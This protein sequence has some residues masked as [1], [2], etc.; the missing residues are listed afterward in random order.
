MTKN[1]MDQRYAKLAQ[2][3]TTYSV[4]IKKGKH[5]WIRC[6]GLTSLQLGKE[7]YK[8]ALKIGAHPYL[9]IHDDSLGSFY[10]SNAQ[11][12]QL[13]YPALIEEH[14]AN[15]ADYTI[16]LI[17][18]ENSR[19]LAN[20]ESSK[21]LLK[22]KTSKKVREIIMKKP[23][24]LTVIPTHGLA[25]DAMMSTDA[26]EDFYFNA[27]L[28]DW[29]KEGKR[30]Q[31]LAKMLTNAK[32]IEVKGIETDLKLSAKARVF[33]PD[34]GEANMPGGEIFT[35]PVDTS[36][37]GHVYF[38]FPLLRSGKFIRDIRFW[39]E[40]G[41]IVKATAS[42]N[43]KYLHQIL[44]TDEGARRLGEFAIGLNPGITQYMNNVL[45]DEKIQGTIH[46]AIGQAYEECKGI[47]TSQIHMDIV[48]DMKP[49]GSSVIADGVTILKD[50]KILV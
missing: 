37:E 34:C 42:E 12:H 19:S 40:K 23:W 5:V 2:L 46:M 3:L 15:W 47:N 43:E 11:P 41:K 30:L 35:A 22:E 1:Y 7:V 31:K 14:I 49:K 36:V 8:E 21:L 29:E 33:V 28:R 18:Q 50:G 27:T 24:T 25:Q 17:A 39:F 48:K 38:N 4:K 16:S 32:L 26:F 20:V 9:D 6:V 45:F 10:Y 44:D 13:E